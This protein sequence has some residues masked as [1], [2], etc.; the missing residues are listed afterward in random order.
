MLASLAITTRLTRDRPIQ[1]ARPVGQGAPRSWLRRPSL[2]VR[3][4]DRGTFAR[5]LIPGFLIS[6]GAG[7]IIP[8]LNLFVVG[9]FHV[10]L[11]GISWI[12]ALT[13]L[14]TMLAILL[15]P[16]L[17]NRYG[18]VASVVIVQSASIP[19]LAVLG[20]S[21]ILWTVILAMAVRNSLM[22]AGNPI[23]NAF[24]MEQVSPAER[25]VMAAAMSAL[26]SVGWLIAGPYYSILQATLGFTAG[27]AVGF[28]TIIALYSV[29][30]ALYWFWFRKAEDP[31]RTRPDPGRTTG[32]P[33]TTA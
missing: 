6:L 12:F 16:A 28:V 26:W 23:Q 3:I 10:D 15:Q 30:T 25:A 33:A 22:N 24:A 29:A 1:P 8:F 13:S 32:V 5:L 27:Y 7:Q 11:A 9:K 17:A 20:F 19:F 18:K 2:G 14:G 4:T 31:R 21:P